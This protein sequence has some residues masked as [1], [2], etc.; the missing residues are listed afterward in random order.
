M[1]IHIIAQNETRWWKK[2]KKKKTHIDASKWINDKDPKFKI[3]A[4]VRVSKKNIF[5]ET[6]KLQIGRNKFLWLKRLK[7]LF[8]GHMLLIILIT[9]GYWN[10]LRKIITKANQEF[11]KTEKVMKRKRR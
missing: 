2:E 1:I 9:K 4:I 6:L 5:F 10:L 11:F 8:Q 7:K 3:A